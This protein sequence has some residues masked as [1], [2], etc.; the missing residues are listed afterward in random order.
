MN[1]HFRLGINIHERA[2]AAGLGAGQKLA[3]HATGSE[4]DRK[5]FTHRIAAFT[6]LAYLEMASIRTK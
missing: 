6:L 3:D 1:F 5:L 4:V 2:D